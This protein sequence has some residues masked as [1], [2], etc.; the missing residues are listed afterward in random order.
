[1][2]AAQARTSKPDRQDRSE[3]APRISFGISGLD[4]ILHG[5]LSAGHLYL[6]EG[7]PGAG[8]TT[9][10]LRLALSNCGAGRRALYITLSESKQE[11][12]GVAASHGWDLAPVPI[13]ELT[14]QEDSLRPEHQ[15]SVFNPEDVE[16]DQ[17]TDLM[18]KKVDEVR[19]EVIIVDSLCE[20]RLLARDS[21]RYRR[22]MLALKSFFEERK[23]TVLLIDNQT[24]DS[25]EPTV[26]SIVHGVIGLE[27]LE[28]E[29]GSERRRV[30]VQKMRGSKF[31]EGFHDYRI[32]TGG[33]VVH[34]RLV[35]AEHRHNGRKDR[36]S[37]G[38]GALDIMLQDGIMRG[39]STL[40]LGAAGVGKSS[41]ASRFACSAADRGE[42]AAIYLFDESM[43]V[44]LERSA[45][46]GVD[47][48]PHIKSGRVHLQQLDPAEVPPGEF[49]NDIRARVQHGAG[50]V[51][52]DSLNGWLKAMPGEQYLQ[53]QM[54]ELLSYL[55]MQGVATFLILAQQGVMGPM[56]AEI[57]VSYLADA[58]VLLRYFEAR[59]EIHKA[60]SIFKKRSGPH[61]STIREFRLR[62]GVIEIGKPLRGFHGV[63]T[64]VPQFVGKDG[65]ELMGTDADN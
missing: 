43:Q 54:H 19:P 46:L 28:R 5:G 26:H 55:G 44:Y 50:V 3:S 13:F 60:I 39:T 9:I 63:L 15:Y 21:F 42:S 24:D 8:K 10:A 64:G 18:S 12:L 4:D 40:L 65:T 36:L 20:L 30:R 45:G 57:D 52:I 59:G 37:T 58:I 32:L 31:R 61:E 38:I 41:L 34:P 49:V 53:L 17:L 14:P 56:Q 51:V 35:A 6:L 27:M 47:L 62:P 16:L 23:C 29:Y 1:M 25:K 48:T 7:T 11:L 2:D 33:V 22:Q